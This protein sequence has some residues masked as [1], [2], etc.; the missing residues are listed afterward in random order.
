MDWGTVNDITE[1]IRAVDELKGKSVTRTSAQDGLITRL[2]SRVTTMTHT[3][4]RYID[5]DEPIE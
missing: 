1:A 3:L 5:S 4:P 2:Y